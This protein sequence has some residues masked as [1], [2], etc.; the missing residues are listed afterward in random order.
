MAAHQENYP[1]YTKG[2]ARHAGAHFSLNN[3]IQPLLPQLRAPQPAVGMIEI[4]HGI[5]TRDLDL[6]RLIISAVLVY[7]HRL[8]QG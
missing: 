3:M 7:C 2:T 1:E 4:K 8:Q 5:M 6:I